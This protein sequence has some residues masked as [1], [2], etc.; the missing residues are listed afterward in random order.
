MLTITNRTKVIKRPFRRPRLSAI[1]ADLPDMLKLQILE[2]VGFSP[3]D[4]FILDYV[5]KY[6]QVC[7]IVNPLFLREILDFKVK[8]PPRDII[9]FKKEAYMIITPNKIQNYAFIT[10]NNKL[11]FNKIYNM[12]IRECTEMVD[13]IKQIRNSNTTTT[14]YPKQDLTDKGM[15]PKQLYFCDPKSKVVMSRGT[16]HL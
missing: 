15:R 1:F 7:K 9:A 10:S 12:Y 4:P 14:N 6:K 5:C 3:N 11:V 2:F 16:K 13:H 8:N